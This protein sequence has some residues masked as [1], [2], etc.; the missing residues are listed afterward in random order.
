MTAYVCQLV[1]PSITTLNF[2]IL[3][4]AS[5]FIV[6]HFTISPSVA[7]SQFT[8]TYTITKSDDS[9]I[10]TWLTFVDSSGVFTF[11]VATNDCD[12]PDVGTYNLK[13]TATATLADGQTGTLSKLFTINLKDP[14]YDTDYGSVGPAIKSYVYYIGSTV[15]FTQPFISDSVNDLYGKTPNES[16]CGPTTVYASD[17]WCEAQYQYADPMASGITAHSP[18]IT[19]ETFNT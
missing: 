6:N 16:I 4:P 11:T 2:W 9:I 15:N 13:I 7:E 18:T 14:C 19:I 8:I 17:V 5:T 10:P 3:K 1:A 12:F